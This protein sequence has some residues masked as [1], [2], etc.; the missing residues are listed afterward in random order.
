MKQRLAMAR[1][2]LCDPKLLILDEPFNGLDPEG[3]AKM[4]QLLLDLNQRQRTT[5]I[6]S[7][8]LL[9]EISAIADT[10][11]VL[12]QGV[13]IQEI[14][15]EKVR[16]KERQCIE[17]KVSNPNRASCVLE[18]KLNIHE[19]DLVSN[20]KILIYDTEIDRALLIKTLVMND[21]GIKSAFLK[22]GSLED[23][24]LKLTR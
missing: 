22:E 23:Y 20:H 6:I 13:L 21:V 11:G 8:H 1:A 7:S 12:K 4:R 17:I 10:I 9:S 16:Q 5:I 3:L 2:L 19:F 14:A 15:M 18:E 24:F